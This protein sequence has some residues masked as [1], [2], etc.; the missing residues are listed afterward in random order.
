[1]TGMIDPAS[2]T[3]AENQMPFNPKKAEPPVTDSAFWDL[4]KEIDWRNICRKPSFIK[5]I[6]KKLKD[7]YPETLPAYHSKFYA[8]TK[9]LYDQLIRYANNRYDAFGDGWRD[10]CTEACGFSDALSSDQRWYICSHIVGCGKE[11]YDRVMLDPT[12]ICDYRDY[13]EGFGYCF[14]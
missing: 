5:A 3:D 12:R 7:S 2:A 8:L 9:A 13:K 1:M 14:Y 4:V 10:F 6:Q 11:H